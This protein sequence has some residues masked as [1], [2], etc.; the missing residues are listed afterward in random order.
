MNGLT[1]CFV[2]TEPGQ[3]I[4]DERVK[5]RMKLNMKVMGHPA[6]QKIT[7]G[8]PTYKERF[9]PPEMAMINYFISKVQPL[10]QI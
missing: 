3:P 8:K 1:V 9:L 4:Q 10:Q 7:E 5:Q 6:A 2:G